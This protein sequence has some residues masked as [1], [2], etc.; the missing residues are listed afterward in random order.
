[1]KEIKVTKGDYFGAIDSVVE[2]HRCSGCQCLCLDRGDNYCRNCGIKL[3][4]TKYND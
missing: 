4:W 2:M 3:D 1:M